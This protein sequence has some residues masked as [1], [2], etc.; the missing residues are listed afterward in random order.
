M[1][2]GGIGYQ[3]CDVNSMIPEQI[4]GNPEAPDTHFEVCALGV[5]CYDLLPERLPNGLGNKV[6]HKVETVTC[7][8]DPTPITD[9]ELGVVIAD[10]ISADRR[11]FNLRLIARSGAPD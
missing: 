7:N 1:T 10:S 4:V 2:S 6:I 9:L 5:I 3:W 11:N 8:D